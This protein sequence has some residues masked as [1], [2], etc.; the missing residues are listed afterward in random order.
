MVGDFVKR[1]MARDVALKSAVAAD[2]DVFQM[3]RSRSDADLA[4]VN[5]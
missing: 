1:A 2:R 3:F 5:P 4:A